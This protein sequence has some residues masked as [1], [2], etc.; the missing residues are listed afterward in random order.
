VEKSWI[1]GDIPPSHGDIPVKWKSFLYFHG[2]VGMQ[3]YGVDDIIA[4]G[5]AAKP[6]NQ[7]Q[8]EVFRFFEQRGGRCV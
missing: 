5:Q 1:L 3:I 6:I 8:Y 7:L 4:S 2:I